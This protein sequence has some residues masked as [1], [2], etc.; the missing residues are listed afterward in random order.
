M[1][2]KKTLKKLSYEERFAIKKNNTQVV[3][4]F[5]VSLVDFIF[6]IE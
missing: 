6:K 1:G 5:S 3:V 4:V 2:R